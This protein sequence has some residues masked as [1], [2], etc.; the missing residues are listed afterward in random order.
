VDEGESM[1]CCC[2]EVEVGFGLKD[3]VKVIL[4]A[5]R[6]MKCLVSRRVRSVTY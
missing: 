6:L 2:A 1:G 3:I 4:S 5:T